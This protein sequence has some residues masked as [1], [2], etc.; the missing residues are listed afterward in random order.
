[1]ALWYEKYIR[2]IRCKQN[3][4]KKFWSEFLGMF[5]FVFIADGTVATAIFYTPESIEELSEIMYINVGIA[6]GYTIGLY[7]CSENVGY[8]NAALTL[9]FGILGK[10]K[11]KDVITYV[12]AQILGAFLAEAFIYGLYEGKNS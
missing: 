12:L 3:V 2:K 10:M 7:I 1:M 6:F 8:L 4:Y 5:A 9:V 11:L